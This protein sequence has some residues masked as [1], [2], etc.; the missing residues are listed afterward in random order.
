MARL[1]EIAHLF[2]M[3]GA[4]RD[5]MSWEIGQLMGRPSYLRAWLPDL[6]VTDFVDWEGN[7]L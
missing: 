3:M 2:E 1:F 7:V 5:E 6:W 4:S